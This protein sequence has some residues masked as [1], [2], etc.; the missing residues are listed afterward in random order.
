MSLFQFANMSS[1]GFLFI[2]GFGY[3]EIEVL[4]NHNKGE[5]MRYGRAQSIIL[6]SILVNQPVLEHNA[7]GTMGTLRV[8][9][10][11]RYW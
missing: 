10:Y 6:Q 11:N 3:M 9:Y 8:K 4:S 2:I 7:P 5:S 1:K